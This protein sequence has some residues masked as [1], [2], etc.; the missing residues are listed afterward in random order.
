MGVPFHELRLLEGVDQSGDVTGRA[1]QQF[2]ELPLVHGPVVVKAPD[3]LGSSGGETL[4]G[5]T[6]GHGRTQDC[7]EGKQSSQDGHLVIM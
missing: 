3:H 7:T 4:V 2:A 1:L 5:E 6:L